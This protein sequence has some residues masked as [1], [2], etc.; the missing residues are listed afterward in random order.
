V[1]VFAVNLTASRWPRGMTNSDDKL[2]IG[3]E[4]C[5]DD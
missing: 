4:C 2:W 3:G 1:V 5:I